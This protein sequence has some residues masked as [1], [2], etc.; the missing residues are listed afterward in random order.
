MYLYIQVHMK[1]L[2]KHMYFALLYKILSTYS[3][4]TVYILVCTEYVCSTY[5]VCT[6][7]YLV[8]T[9]TYLLL[10]LS[11]ALQDFEYILSMYCVHT[12]MY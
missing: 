11:P 12:S 7:M 5:C 8:C 2:L 6:S 3:V 10:L 4:H 9:C 1:Y